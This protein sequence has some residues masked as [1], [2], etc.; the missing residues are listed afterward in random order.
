MVNE[1]NIILVVLAGSLFMFL[2]VLVVVIFVVTYIKRARLKESQFQLELKNKDLDSLRGIIKAQEA[3]RGRLGISLH[4]EIGP[5]L[6]LVKIN[7]MKHKRVFDQGLIMKE[8]FDTDCELIDDIIS[9]IRNVS[10]RL[11]PSFVFKEG[12][13]LSLKRFGESISSFYL[14][15]YSTIDDERA[16]DNQA[17]SNSYLILLEILNNLMK[18]D[19]AIKVSL[20]LDLSEKGLEIRINHDGIGMTMKEFNEKKEAGNGLGLNSIQSRLLILNGTID[21]Y[22]E[23][24]KHITRIIIPLAY[25]NEN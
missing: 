18:H 8:D 17:I 20:Y 1:T 10:I 19:Q 5:H 2:L 15:V 4:D 11:K 23:K 22:R 24:E 7:L 13:A 21:M 25:D 14:T 3:E 12:L 16:I 6:T 9:K